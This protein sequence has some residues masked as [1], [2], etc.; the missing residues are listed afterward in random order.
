M[1]VLILEG[2]SRC[3]KTSWYRRNQS[4]LEEIFRGGV[5]YTHV[6]ET[7]HGKVLKQTY[8]LRKSE[9]D[10]PDFNWKLGLQYVVAHYDHVYNLERV[11]ENQLLV[12]D[13]SII[14]TIAIQF[15]GSFVCNDDYTDAY[16]LAKPYFEIL[17]LK[18]SWSFPFVLFLDPGVVP[19]E[20]YSEMFDKAGVYRTTMNCINELNKYYVDCSLS[21]EE[22]DESC[23]HLLRGLKRTQS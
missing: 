19:M 4:K 7:P 3:G 21:A 12:V 9:S 23:E 11:A 14:S 18:N 20:R 10:D 6:H 5:R 15:G 2:I 16:S 8:L 17:C 13:R 1:P 22:V